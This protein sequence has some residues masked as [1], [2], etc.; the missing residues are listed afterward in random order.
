VNR[1]SR[2]AGRNVPESPARSQRDTRLSPG[3]DDRRVGGCFG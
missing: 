1:R 2:H 3:G